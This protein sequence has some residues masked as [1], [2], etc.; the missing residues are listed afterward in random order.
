MHQRTHSLPP[1]LAG[2]GLAV[3]AALLF[4]ILN[5]VIRFSDPHLTVWHMMFGRSLFGLVFLLVAA[6]AGGLNLLGRKRGILLLLGLTGTGGILCL[7]LAL[8]LIPLFQAL[9]LF[10]TYPA[11]AAL[12]SPVLTSDRIVLRDWICIGLAFCGTVLVLWSGQMQG[13]NPSLGHLA[14][15]GASTG[16]GLTMTLI[17]R[18]S[19]VNNA[20]T[21]IFY[22]SA[23][24]IVICF[25]PLLHEDVPFLVQ[26]QGLWWLLAIGFFAVS[27][28]I[29]TNQ[30]LWYIP[31][32]KVGTISMLEVPLGAVYG[33]VLFAETL[34]WS[35]LFGGCL[36]MASGLGLIRSSA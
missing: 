33:Y 36:I 4:S 7:T 6:R 17:R 19:P 16:L 23:V 35:T 21:P 28:H 9:I 2:A 34:G 26:S 32:P 10:Y 5:V 1:S 11:V 22:I 31:S 13:F 8:L 3:L 12:L 18:V 30:S 29:A 27:A 20:M 15:I 14:A 25:F 24:G